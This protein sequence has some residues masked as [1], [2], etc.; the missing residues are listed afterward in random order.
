VHG[1][2]LKQAAISDS[3]TLNARYTGLIC[4]VAALGGLLFGY[5]YVVIG[6]AKPF[7]E[8][9]FRLTTSTQIGWANSCALLGCLAGSIVSGAASDRFGRKKLLL[10]AAI[11]FAGSSVFTGLAHSIDQFIVARIL[12]GAAI[13]IASNVS[14]TYIAEVSPAAWR[15]R[16]V[17]LNQLTIVVGILGAQIVNLLIAE[18]VPAGATAEMIR[19]S[20][21]GQWGWRWMFI[22]VGAPS[23]LFLLSALFVPESPRWQLLHGERARAR[24]T[25]ARIGGASYAQAAVETVEATESELAAAPKGAY[26]GAFRRVLLVGVVLAVLQQWSGINVIFNYAEEIYRS[27]GYGVN[28]ILFNIV[29]TGAVNLLFTFIALRTVDRWGRRPLMLA[30]CA[31]IAISHVLI[32]SAYHFGLRGWPVLVFTLLTIGCYA[33]SLAPVTWVIISEIFPTQIRGAGVAISVSALWIA[34]FLLTFTFPMLQQGLGAAGTFWV[35]ALICAAGFFFVRAR[36]PETKGKTLEQ[37]EKELN[38]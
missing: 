28:D 18:R 16:L 12:G 13:G 3:E 1:P 19:A 25:F 35:Y 10:L 2:V 7:Y 8:A 23:L 38:A 26:F 31:A 30:G 27:A 24:A 5:D 22:A 4:A 15:G 33:M 36:V 20:W 17:S 32:G 29:V 37:I 21:N 11:L 34:C 6:G 9:Y 14:P